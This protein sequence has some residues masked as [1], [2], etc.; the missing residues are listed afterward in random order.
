MTRLLALVSFVVACVCFIV[1]AAEIGKIETSWGL[2]F[3][4]LGLALLAIGGG[5]AYVEAKRHG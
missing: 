5:I 3:T 4:A 1:N 2:F